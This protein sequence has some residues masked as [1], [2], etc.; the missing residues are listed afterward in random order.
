MTEALL[1]LEEPQSTPAEQIM[2]EEVNDKLIHISKL[3]ER[4]GNGKSQGIGELE[5]GLAKSELTPGFLRT[6]KQ[7]AKP[8]SRSNN[9][10]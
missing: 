7:T 3:L 2:L 8:G 1:R 10:K 9:A 4:I 5:E 6:I